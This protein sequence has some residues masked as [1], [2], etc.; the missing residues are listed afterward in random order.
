MPA[1][2]DGVRW[3]AADGRRRSHTQL[4]EAAPA[5]RAAGLEH[6]SGLGGRELVGHAIVGMVQ[7][8]GDQRLIGIAFEEGDRHLHAHARDGHTPVAVMGPTAGHPQPT[9]A[10]LVAIIPTIPVEGDLD[11]TV[12]VFGRSTLCPAGHRK[13]QDVLHDLF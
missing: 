12:R 3:T 11:T 5:R 8:D 9:A 6:G 7:T 1:R 2:W 4:V 10:A 13:V